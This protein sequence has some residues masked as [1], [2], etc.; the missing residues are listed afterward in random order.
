MQINRIQTA[1]SLQNHLKSINVT[2]ARVKC[3]KTELELFQDILIHEMRG[4]K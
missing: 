2:P 4:G 1:Q 3:T